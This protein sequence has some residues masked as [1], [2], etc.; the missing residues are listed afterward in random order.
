MKIGAMNHPAR[1]PLAEIEWIDDP[2]ELE[3]AA[4]AW[5]TDHAAT[6][7]IQRFAPVSNK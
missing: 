5:L 1:N 7:R 3:R 6:Y 2:A 4:R